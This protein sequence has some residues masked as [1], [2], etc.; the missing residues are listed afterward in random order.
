MTCNVS[1][2]CI[3]SRDSTIFQHFIFFFPRFIL[4]QI[5]D[6]N[7][8]LGCPLE[9]HGSEQIK[10]N[11]G[12]HDL[13]LYFISKL[14][15]PWTSMVCVTC[16][17]FVYRTGHPCLVELHGTPFS[18]PFPVSRIKSNLS[19]PYDDVSPGVSGVPSPLDWET[20]CVCLFRL[21]VCFP[22][23]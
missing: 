3:H 4:G 10:A 20:I 6:S 22:Q 16:N 7:G 14:S 5:C 11:I 18:L 2:A 19:S 8:Q 1:G 9:S 15:I 13:L 23:A 21:C 12:F 17:F